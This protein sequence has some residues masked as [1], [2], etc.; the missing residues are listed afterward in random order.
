MALEGPV[1]WCSNT[2]RVEEY[3]SKLAV[4]MAEDFVSGGFCRHS[5]QNRLHHC[6]LP[7]PRETAGNSG[8]HILKGESIALGSS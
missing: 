3:P 1:V 5:C 6:D 4:E 7:V 8:C 2:G